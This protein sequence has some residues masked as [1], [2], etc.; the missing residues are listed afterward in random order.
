MRLSGTAAAT[1]GSRARRG[2]SSATR[3]EMAGAW[4]QADRHSQARQPLRM[5]P[6]SD[7]QGRSARGHPIRR[8]RMSLLRH[9]RLW[10]TDPCTE[11]RGPYRWAYS[12]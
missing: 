8:L 10:N 4:S 3:S 12:E 7:R 9:R 2:C 1:S 5:V 11:A 6:Q